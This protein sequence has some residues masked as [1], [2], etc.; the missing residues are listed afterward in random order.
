MLLQLFHTIHKHLNSHLNSKHSISLLVPS[1]DVFCV[2]I[3]TMNLNHRIN[4]IQAVV[5]PLL[6]LTANVIESIFYNYW[7]LILEYIYDLSLFT[8]SDDKFLHLFNY[9]IC[10]DFTPERSRAIKYYSARGPPLGAS[11]N[12][13]S[14]TRN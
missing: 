5:L 1:I 7:I 3:L 8:S 12:P 9:S 4:I 13:P 2:K 10:P 11:L 14:E 6:W